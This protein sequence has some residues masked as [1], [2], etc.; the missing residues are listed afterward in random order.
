MTPLEAWI[1]R[2]YLDS[3]GLVGLFM[4]NVVFPLYLFSLLNYE[5]A[6]GRRMV[7]TV[8]DDGIY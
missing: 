4:L 1:S 5:G 8:L 2:Y 6:L 7:N 3:W